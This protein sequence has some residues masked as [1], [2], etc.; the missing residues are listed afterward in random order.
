MFVIHEFSPSCVSRNNYLV[1]YCCSTQTTSSKCGRCDTHCKSSLDRGR[2]AKHQSTAEGDSVTSSGVHKQ[3]S[4]ALWERISAG[5]LG[6]TERCCK[7]NDDR[8]DLGVDWY[9]GHCCFIKTDS[10]NS[11]RSASELENM[12]FRRCITPNSRNHFSRTPRHTS[13]CTSTPSRAKHRPQSL[14][15]QG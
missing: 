5:F 12:I 8:K 7:H 6:K 15:P 4:C 9:W 11:V 10:D 14:M 3:V 13:I 2:Q 1:W